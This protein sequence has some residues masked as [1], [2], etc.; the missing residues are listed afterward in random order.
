MRGG[1]EYL[2]L[3]ERSDGHLESERQHAMSAF[4]DENRHSKYS[5]IVDLVRD[6]VLTTLSR[7]SPSS[8]DS[9]NIVRLSC[10]VYVRTPR[11]LLAMLVPVPHST[12]GPP[13]TLSLFA[14]PKTSGTSCLVSTR[15]FKLNVQS[16]THQR[17]TVQPR[18]RH[19]PISECSTTDFNVHGEIFA[20]VLRHSTV[21]RRPRRL[22]Q[23]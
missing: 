16:P 12:G 17:P 3:H 9:P 22:P 20:A 21:L 19:I 14:L 6:N 13:P 8:W 5:K 10:G 1:R 11:H 23:A 4:S 18:A 7:L 2:W 15:N